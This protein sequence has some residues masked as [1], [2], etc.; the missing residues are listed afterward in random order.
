MFASTSQIPPF[1]QM[2]ITLLVIVLLSLC[3]YYLIY[4]GNNH[5]EHKIKV[6]WT[7]IARLIAVILVLA[8][9]SYLFNL[10]PI[11]G[12]TTFS[13]FVSVIIAFVLN[14]LVNI[15]EKKGIKRAYGMLIC[16]VVIVLFFVGLLLSV[17]PSI[18]DQVQ[19]FVSNLPSTASYA[20]DSLTD[21]LEKIDKNNYVDITKI[22]NTLKD[23]ISSS[24][25]KY[26]NSTASFISSI[27]SNLSKLISLVLVPIMTYFLVVDKDTFLGAI[28]NMV[29]NRHRDDLK[30]LYDQINTSMN[31]IVR[32]RL[33]MAVF[34]GI[35]TTIVLLIMKIEFA[36]VIGLIT[37]VAD[38]IPYIGPFLGFAPAII[39]AFIASP[40]KAL[41][42]GFLFLFIQWAE[43]N[44]LGPKILGNSTGLH[45]LAILLSLVIGGGVFGVWGMILSVP[46]LSLINIL[47]GYVK[48]KLNSKL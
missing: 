4:I 41:W 47:I 7:K 31:E 22:N 27:P 26:L 17:I 8:L 40:I 12:T 35:V 34:V 19:K 43:N 16:Y 15:L 33:L 13:L 18:V 23:F 9:I 3:I 20:M 1:F 29:P 48:L 30:Y 42:V 32:G 14:P 36:V 2:V 44:L 39:F 24:S 38:I 45:P 46:C 25:Q 21:F 6:N 10:Y 11:L 37:M 5:T 28:K